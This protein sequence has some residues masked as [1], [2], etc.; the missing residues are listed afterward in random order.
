MK[1][2]KVSKASEGVGRLAAAIAV[3]S[4]PLASAADIAI[5]GGRIDDPFFVIVKKGIDDAS[6]DCPKRAAVR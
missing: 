6:K 5:V 4:S 3:L 1:H 2:I